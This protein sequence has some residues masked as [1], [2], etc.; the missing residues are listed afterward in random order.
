MNSV[1]FSRSFFRLFFLLF[2][3]AI[4]LVLA[5][6]VFAAG[7]ADSAGRDWVRSFNIGKGALVLN[8]VIILIQWANFLIFLILLNKILIKPLRTHMETRNSKVENHLSS[9]E[10]DQKEA[11]GYITQYE[12]SLSEIRRENNERIVSLQQEITN[13][14]LKKQTEIKENASKDLEQAR[15]RIS[16]EATKARSELKEMANDLASQIANRLAGRNVA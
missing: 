9:S 5:S 4:L 10:R 14:S 13:E 11:M 1:S 7:G 6:D 16:T 3:S 12:D 8:P 2:V 15:S